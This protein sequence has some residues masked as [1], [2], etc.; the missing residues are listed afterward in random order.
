VIGKAKYM[1]RINSNYTLDDRELTTA[2][3]WSD[4]PA[5]LFPL[6]STFDLAY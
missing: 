1:I 3:G 5:K 4:D 2:V 6:T